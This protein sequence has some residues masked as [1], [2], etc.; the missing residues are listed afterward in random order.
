MLSSR[1][2][3]GVL[4]LSLSNDSPPGVKR[5]RCFSFSGLDPPLD[6]GALDSALPS[7]ELSSCS[8]RP[9]WDSFGETIVDVEEGRGDADAGN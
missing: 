1:T 4:L 5:T 3:K 7:R 9:R 6:G 2:S 8:S